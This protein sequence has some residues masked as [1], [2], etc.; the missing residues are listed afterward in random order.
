MEPTQ[1]IREKI[2]LVS[3]IS[4]YVTLKKA[5]RNFKGLCPF[6]NESTPSFMVSPERQI[7]HCFGCQKG[8]DC[9]SFLMEYEKMDFPEAL[10]TLAQKAGVELPR[11][12]FTF[13]TTSIKEKLY[14]MNKKAAN[15]YHYLLI[16]HKIGSK[17]KIYVEER[18][19]SEKLATTLSR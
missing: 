16:K 5:G 13:P 14:E 2:D 19:I 10:R 6:H 18:G 4:E 11:D 7:W 1:Q 15:L 12:R 17:A 3:Y 9:F 8:G